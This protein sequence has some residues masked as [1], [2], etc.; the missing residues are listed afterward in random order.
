M[1]P[2]WKGDLLLASLK[3]GLLYQI[4]LDSSGEIIS[5]KIIINNDQGYGRLRDIEVAPDGSIYIAISNRDGRGADPFPT[6]EDDRIIRWS[7]Q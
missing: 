2:E 7:K 4:D 6:D 1:F 5:D 3:A